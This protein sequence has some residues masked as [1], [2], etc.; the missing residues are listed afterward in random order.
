MKT[1][2]VEK[3]KS[4][5]I[6]VIGQESWVKSH[7]DKHYEDINHETK[8]TGQDNWEKDHGIKIMTI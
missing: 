2:S 5:E 7:G 6:R 3:D 4:D 1:L 8:I